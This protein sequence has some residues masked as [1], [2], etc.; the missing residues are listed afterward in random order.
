MGELHIVLTMAGRGSRFANAGFTTP[1]P[2]I[3][4][5]GR[6]MFKKALASLDGITAKRHHTIVIRGEHDRQYNLAQQLRRELEGVNVVVTDEPPIGA[7][8]DALRS[9][10]YIELHH[11]VIV[12]DCDLWFQSASYNRMVEE[13]LAGNSDIVGGLLTFTADSPR[14]SYAK[15]DEDDYVTETAE[16]IVISDRAITGA[17]YF[18]PGHVFTRAAKQLLEKP[19]SETMPEYYLSHL[20]NVLLADGGRIKAARVDDFASFGTP[21]ELEEYEAAQ[22]AA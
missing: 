6:P 14:Y 12:L 13:S 8:R 1:K 2:L 19:L 9:E 3:P 15:L 11:G 17:Y 20:Y 4:V 18:A 16:K 22:R 10:P 5:D 21:E 7:V